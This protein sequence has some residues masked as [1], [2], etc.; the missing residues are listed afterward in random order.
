VI[1]GIGGAAAATALGVTVVD[2]GG[3]PRQEAPVADG[4]L[5]DSA[6]GDAA[7]QL[8]DRFAPIMMMKHQESACDENGEPFLPS[9]VD[10]VLDNP[11][12]SLR[13]LSLED[14]V[15]MRAPGAS[16]IAGLGEGRV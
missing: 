9:S 2:A 13:Q 6:S 4:G 11:E 7:Q 8:V 16:D 10:I 14:P 3:F 12:V 1:A 5:G 15:V